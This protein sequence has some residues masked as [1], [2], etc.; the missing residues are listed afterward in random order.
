MSKFNPPCSGAQLAAHEVPFLENIDHG[1]GHLRARIRI[2][3]N[4]SAGTRRSDQG[5]A[6]P[7]QYPACANSGRYGGFLQAVLIERSQWIAALQS[8]DMLQSHLLRARWQS[9]PK[10]LSDD[11]ELYRLGPLS[12]RFFQRS[13]SGKQFLACQEI[14]KGFHRGFVDA[15]TEA[16]ERTL[17]R[18][19]GGLPVQALEAHS[20]SESSG[21]DT[22]IRVKIGDELLTH[23]NQY[24]Q[25]AQGGQRITQLIEEPFARAGRS[26]LRE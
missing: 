14:E 5:L 6:A 21:Q 12:T 18:G 3:V 4:Q 10:L 8:L 13:G 11:L 24:T 23:H 25:M 9:F 17:D 7:S 2:A 16:A 26:G 1:V 20:A 19:S 15:D 22:R